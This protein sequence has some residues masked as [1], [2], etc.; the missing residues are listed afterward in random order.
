M[1]FTSPT[2]QHNRSKGKG[3]SS[4]KD[5]KPARRRRIAAPTSPYGDLP[6][7]LAPLPAPAPAQVPQQLGMAQAQAQAQNLPLLNNNN[8]SNSTYLDKWIMVY[9]FTTDGLD[10]G[11]IAIL[12]VFQE[13]GDI[14]KHVIGK[15]NYIFIYFRQPHEADLALR[16]NGQPL[17]EGSSVVIGVQRVTQELMDKMGHEIKDGNI[18][19]TTQFR[20]FRAFSAI[21][22]ATSD[23]DINL[24][25]NRRQ[26]ICSWIIEMFFSY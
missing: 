9:G 1:E 7:A 15:G 6:P 23:D 4:V 10:Q 25:P 14:E 17:G 2:P 22:Y 5:P 19:Q 16:R 13:D 20:A 26:N 11:S 24:A 18:V 12:Q 3:D 8:N 21:R